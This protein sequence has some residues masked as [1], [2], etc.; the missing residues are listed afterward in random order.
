MGS[1]GM[2]M[3]RF[4]KGGERGIGCTGRAGLFIRMGP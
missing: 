1:L 3:G 2:G 4:M